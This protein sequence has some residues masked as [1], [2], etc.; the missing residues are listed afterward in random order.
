MIWFNKQTEW[1]EG[2]TYNDPVVTSN[3]LRNWFLEMI[4]TFPAMNGPYSLGDIDNDM[5]T[6]YCIGTHVIYV[7]FRWTVAEKAYGVMKPNAEK[8]GVGFF[9]VSATE[10]D[11]LFPNGRGK[12]QPI[13]KPDN[14]SSIQ[15]MKN[16][17]S[18]K[19][20]HYSKQNIPSKT[21]RGS[22]GNTKPEQQKRPWWKRLFLR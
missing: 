7:T 22:T 17:A 3:N 16:M 12:S 6:D 8:F 20:I 10:G 4:K 14:L 19:S 9:D 13:D 15:Q 2:H 5:V 21:E 18:V 11:I 1:G